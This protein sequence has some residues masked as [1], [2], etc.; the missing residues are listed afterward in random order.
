MSMLDI[1]GRPLF[2]ETGRFLPR[3]YPDGRGETHYDRLGVAVPVDF[4]D[5]L[6][7][8]AQA[9]GTSMSD[10]VRRAVESRAA[11]ILADRK[12]A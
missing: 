2:D 7:S 4:R 8:A 10:L 9:A 1:P 3:Q 6:K 5:Y 11:E 12:A